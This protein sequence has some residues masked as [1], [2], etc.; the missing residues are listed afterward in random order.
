MADV[1][2]TPEITDILKRSTVEGNIL[3]LPEGQL[4]RK[5]YME[6]AKAIKNA[7]GAWKTPK[8]GFV[9]DGDPMKKLGLALDSGIVINEKKKFQAF[10]TP[11]GLASRVA[12]M[13]DVKDR[14]V[15]EPSAGNG[16]LADACSFEGAVAVD[17]IEINPKF[18][19]ELSKQNYPVIEDDFLT[20]TPSAKYDRVVMNPP[21]TKNQ[22]VKHVA[23]ALKFLKSGGILT[24]IMSPNTSR[25]AFQELVKPFRHEI[26][27]VDAG[28]FKE[29]GTSIA[30]IILQIFKP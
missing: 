18:C 27:P 7:G 5:V 15:L 1:K 20:V 14:R 23:H 10:F 28:E 30:T 2:L 26:T 25:K 17:C 9:F 3:K 13:A 12:S 6:V 22:D 21:F 29:S 8:K 11:E 16:R 24:A 19:E 4:E